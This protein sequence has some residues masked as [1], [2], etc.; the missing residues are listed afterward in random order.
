M[1]GNKK[2]D[3]FYCKSKTTMTTKISKESTLKV[4]VWKAKTFASNN[5]PS[6]EAKENG[7][8]GI[9]RITPVNVGMTRI[10][11]RMR[12]FHDIILSD[13]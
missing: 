3:S 7:F 9:Q 12:T 8:E 10:Q 4:D 11:S 13:Y 6:C 5:C 1:N 2:S